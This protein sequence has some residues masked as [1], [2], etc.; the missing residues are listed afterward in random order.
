ML[1]ST[2]PMWLHSSKNK[3]GSQSDKPREFIK[4]VILTMK[5]ELEPVAFVSFKLSAGVYRNMDE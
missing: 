2:R 1:Q 4:S 5:D 3:F